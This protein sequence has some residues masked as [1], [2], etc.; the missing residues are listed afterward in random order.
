[1]SEQSDFMKK[2]EDVRLAEKEAGNIINAAKKSAENI[3]Q[4]AK[5]EVVSVKSKNEE[6]IINIKDTFVRARG[7]EIEKEVEGI[8]KKSKEKVAKSRNMCIDKKEAEGLVDYFL[9]SVV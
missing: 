5:K 6:Q 2:V 3:L 8:I 9:E 7:E 1:M 4:A